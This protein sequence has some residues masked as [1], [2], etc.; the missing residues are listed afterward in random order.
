[1]KEVE[2]ERR[3]SSTQTPPS[4]SREPILVETSEDEH[5]KWIA[6]MEGE[7]TNAFDLLYF[8]CMLVGTEIVDEKITDTPTNEPL[9][10][11]WNQFPPLPQGPLGIPSPPP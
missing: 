3:R 1:M 7:G 10:D 6:K 9:R 11:D 4:S 2:E 8:Y 5:Q